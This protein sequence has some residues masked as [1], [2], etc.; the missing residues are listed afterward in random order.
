M[1]DQHLPESLQ[2][3]MA[4]LAEQVRQCAVVVLQVML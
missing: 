1:C 3:A 2:D 4:S